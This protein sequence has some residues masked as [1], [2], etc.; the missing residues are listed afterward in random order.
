MSQGITKEEIKDLAQRRHVI[1]REQKAHRPLSEGY[2]YIGLAG[3][4]EFSRR[5]DLPMDLSDKPQGDQGENFITPIGSIQ[6]KTARQAKNLFLELNGT[7]KADILVLAEYDEHGDEVELLGW[8]FA[9]TLRR[10]PVR[11]FGYG[12]LNHYMDSNDLLPMGELHNLL[13]SMD[14]VYLDRRNS[15]IEIVK[16][17]RLKRMSAAEGQRE[18]TSELILDLD[19][20]RLREKQEFDPDADGDAYIPPPELDSNGQA[21]TYRVKLSLGENTDEQV[22]KVFGERGMYFKSSEKSGQFGVL[23]IESEIVDP[24]GVFDKFKLNSE[25]LTTLVNQRTG[26]SPVANLMRILGSPLKRGSSLQ[27]QRKHVAK[28]LAGNPQCDARIQWQARCGT[29]EEDIKSLSGE[30]NWPEKKDEEGNVIGHEAQDQC[31][32]CKGDVIAR[33]ATRKRLP[34]QTV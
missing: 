6:I 20:P 4:Y 11:D 33:V 29:C 13:Y 15:L 8:E 7:S 31:P 21:I 1:H 14:E 17:R 19:D 32:D 18:S 9:S 10:K 2:E 23:R 12:V 34:L 28:V 16:K 30:R 26:T 25:W 5:F 22:K 27:E 3:Q 24:G